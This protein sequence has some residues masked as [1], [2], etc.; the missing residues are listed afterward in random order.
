MSGLTELTARP[1]ALDGSRDLGGER[2]WLVGAFGGDEPHAQVVERR[3]PE[4]ELVRRAEGVPASFM[5]CR[6]RDATPG[7]SVS[8][9]ASASLRTPLSLERSSRTRPTNSSSSRSNCSHGISSSSPSGVDVSVP[10]DGSTS[11]GTISLTSTPRPPASAR[12]SSYASVPR[13]RSMR[14]TSRM[15]NPDARATSARESPR[16]TRSFR[17]RRPGRSDAALFFFFFF[18]CEGASD[19][20][21]VRGRGRAGSRPSRSTTAWSRRS[22]SSAYGDHDVSAHD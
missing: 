12:Q 1:D 2:D 8:S 3:E 21:F 6:R 9:D 7:S 16:S 15:L 18:F 4:P 5:G 13:P 10:P 14:R 20:A 11:A 22:R 19:D 17:I